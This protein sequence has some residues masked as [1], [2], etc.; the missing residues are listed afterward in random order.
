MEQQIKSGDTVEL[1]E[2]AYCLTIGKDYNVVDVSEDGRIIHIKDDDGDYRKRN[3]SEFKLKS[4]NMELKTTKDKVL[5]AAAKCS[6]AKATL[7]TLFPEAFE[8]G[9][10]IIHESHQKTNLVD[11]KNNYPIL[12]FARGIASS[13][14]R[15]DL[16]DKCLWLDDRDYNW[17][18]TEPNNGYRLLIPTRKTS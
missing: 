16:K 17:E 14:G 9:E 18:M 2:E 15:P 3:K 6:T 8:G 7:E 10:C 1:I 13:H 4:S 5:A 12:G 11:D